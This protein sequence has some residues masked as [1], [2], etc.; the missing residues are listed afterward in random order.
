VINVESAQMNPKYLTKN[1]SA[2]LTPKNIT[3]V[4]LAVISKENKIKAGSA[5]INP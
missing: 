1:Q 2:E 3:N 4:D 5:E